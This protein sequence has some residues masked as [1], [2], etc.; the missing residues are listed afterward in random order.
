MADYNEK[1][2]EI[3]DQTPIELTIG[4]KR[5]ETLQQMIARM[6]H[7]YSMNAVKSGIESFEDA[8]DFD[9]EEEEFKSEHQM[10]DMQEENPIYKPFIIKTDSITKPEPDPP[11]TEPAAALKQ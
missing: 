10:T 5:P 1:G 9:T 11:A 4:Q 2:Q 7:V 6:V 8:D 3:P